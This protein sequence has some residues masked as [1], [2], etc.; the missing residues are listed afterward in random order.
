MRNRFTI[1]ISDVH[2]AQHYSFRQVVKKFAG[3]ALAGILLFWAVIA[4]SLWFALD[5]N[6]Q[7]EHQ[8]EIAMEMYAD[9]VFDLQSRYQSILEEKQVTDLSLAEKIEQLELFDRKLQEIEEVVMGSEQL[10]A[11]DSRDETRQERLRDVQI[12]AL[13]KQY[14]LEVIPSGS[15]VLEFKG[16]SSAFGMRIHPVTG[17]RKK[18]YGMDYRGSRGDAV[19]ATA[20][21]VVVFAGKSSVGF[22]N[23]ITIAHANG[24]KTRYG[25]LHKIHV[26]LGEFVPK[27]QLIGE[28]GSTGISTGTHLHYEVLFVSNRLDPKPFHDWGMKSFEQIFAKVDKVP[29][30]SF[31]DSTNQKISL[32][33]KQLLP[34][35][36]ALKETLFH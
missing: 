27:G 1:T 34:Q 6:A 7:I 25:H 17:E 19:I 26:K 33:E 15:P 14:L 11:A 29:W 13:G 12:S 3:Y 28:I 23:M 36:V 35:D 30:G 18:H 16:I 2:G 32:V 20:E 31:I 10:V 24:F 8:H 22:G 9:Q 5:K 4:L 21:G